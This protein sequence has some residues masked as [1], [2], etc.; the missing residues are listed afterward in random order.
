MYAAS[1][2]TPPQSRHL[3]SA[4][5]HER[6]I[7][8]WN[9]VRE[10]LV[11]R[12]SIGAL[13]FK[14]TLLSQIPTFYS[15]LANR[16]PREW[17]VDSRCSNAHIYRSTACNIKPILTSHRL[18]SSDAFVVNSSATEQSTIQTSPSAKNIVNIIEIVAMLSNVQIAIYNNKSRDKLINLLWTRIDLLLLNSMRLFFK[19]WLLVCMQS[20]RHAKWP[21]IVRQQKSINPQSSS[22]QSSKKSDAHQM[23]SPTEWRNSKKSAM[24][25]MSNWLRQKSSNWQNSNRKRLTVFGIQQ[26]LLQCHSLLRSSHVASLLLIINRSTNG[27]FLSLLNLLNEI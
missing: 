26:W 14:V 1:S 25:F 24:Q 12:F 17:H 9:V 2:S 8:V 11:A 18:E 3:Y 13:P 20:G 7:H 10:K 4:C 6:F 5:P 19:R 15:V 27:H 22:I 23:F 21:Q 16:I